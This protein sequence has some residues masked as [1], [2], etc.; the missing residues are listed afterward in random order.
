[1]KN[2]QTIFLLTIL[3]IA[4]LSLFLTN[5]L[6]FPNDI[7]INN[8]DTEKVLDSNEDG[9]M[10][11]LFEG[12]G[13]YTNSNKI[14]DYYDSSRLAE[15]LI[16]SYNYGTTELT[17]FPE[18]KYES[19]ILANDEYLEYNSTYG[20]N[21]NIM[22]IDNTTYDYYSDLQVNVSKVEYLTSYEDYFDVV[23]ANATVPSNN[24]Y[25]TPPVPIYDNTY[26]SFEDKD[27]LHYGAWAE[28]RAWD[29]HDYDPNPDNWIFSP[30]SYP[31]QL[32]N[33]QYYYE[34]EGLF[35]P[36]IPYTIPMVNVSIEVAVEIINSKMGGDS[37]LDYQEY[38]DLITHFYRLTLE[39]ISDPLQD[40][41]LQTHFL[42][43]PL[44]LWSRGDEIVVAENV[45]F[46]ASI[47]YR[48]GG[49]NKKYSFDQYSE[50][51]NGGGDG[52]LSVTEI[53]THQ[54]QFTSPD[55]IITPSHY[56]F[57]NRT[58]DQL[59]ID[60][61]EMKS[62]T[63]TMFNDYSQWKGY[64]AN[65]QNPIITFNLTAT[66][67]GWNGDWQGNEYGYPFY[68][69]IGG[70]P[71]NDPED[72]NR[73]GGVDP[74]GITFPYNL[75]P[76]T[77]WAKL[78]CTEFDSKHKFDWDV[79][80]DS[81]NGE[82]NHKWD[83]YASVYNETSPNV[84]PYNY[85]DLSIDT[86]GDDLLIKGWDE[87]IPLDTYNITAILV[88]QLSSYEWVNA[89]FD[90]EVR[91]YI[92]DDQ[93]NSKL[94][95]EDDELNRNPMNWTVITP[96]LPNESYYERDIGNNYDKIIFNLTTNNW[97]SQ[98]YD[99]YI[100]SYDLQFDRF[101]FEDNSTYT[102]G[103]GD[104]LLQAD[105]HF[106]RQIDIDWKNISLTGN[107]VKN[108]WIN[109]SL[110]S[111][112]I[113]T[114]LY[115]NSNDIPI[116]NTLN[117]TNIL[118]NSGSLGY[119]I[120]IDYD[121]DKIIPEISN[122]TIHDSLT[123]GETKEFNVTGY[124]GVSIH[125]GFIIFEN[126]ISSVRTG[127]ELDRNLNVF[128]LNISFENL[129]LG[130]YKAWYGLQDVAGNFN[131]TEFFYCNVYS[132]ILPN[133]FLLWTD[134]KDPDRDGNFMLYWTESL[135]ADNYSIY[136]EG[137]LK[138]EGIT[139]LNYTIEGYADG[140]YEVIIVSFNSFGNSSSN[141]IEV[142]IERIVEDGDDDEDIGLTDYDW[143][144]ILILIGGSVVTIVVTVL[145]VKR[146]EIT[147]ILRGDN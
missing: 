93:T 110:Q 78:K 15:N 126:N 62:I 123:E 133:P 84:F 77:C 49:V 140:T 33:P 57:D 83:V 128:F 10:E 69:M 52:V 94:Y 143:V 9:G 81:G 85:K 25:P 60:T 19:I 124:D 59:D 105:T 138:F 24:P 118:W 56:E 134:A 22:E 74:T 70:I 119:Y 36:Y 80:Q 145:I 47:M 41:P 73:V 114:F 51:T 125:R 14:N 66:G 97:D 92:K 130:V 136:F 86:S 39:T 146:K 28:A 111:S 107:F 88:D 20:V 113:K 67:V 79:A 95:I 43:T 16:P 137:E 89:T 101:Y 63:E 122:W 61:M 64:Q 29:Y 12:F 144:I 75:L 117:H 131:T 40:I 55:T 44:P 108:L 65:H 135:N 58:I 121:L 3:T 53:L 27:Y 6:G 1:M 18:Y 54:G 21:I 46:D 31:Y 129:S 2:K 76:P 48:D 116:W 98:V 17:V 120:D 26:M 7:S 142:E 106:E 104:Y 32:E 141:D 42:P 102:S 127:F 109:S 147:V 139:K 5:S 23:G 8:P 96:F 35:Y 132:S 50:T 13:N 103:V 71:R 82:Y 11:I 34:D 37:E 115:Y 72:V 68:W 4:T 112:Y 91:G 90:L 38:W 87:R 100:Y 30:K 99:G 45:T